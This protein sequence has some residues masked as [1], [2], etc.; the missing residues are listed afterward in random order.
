MLLDKNKKKHD[1]QKFRDCV[2]F[3]SEKRDSNNSPIKSK[4]N[5]V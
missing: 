4:L 5:D 1:I 3:N 2:K